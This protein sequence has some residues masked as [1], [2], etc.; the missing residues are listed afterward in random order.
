MFGY[1]KYAFKMYTY[2]H[3]FPK[4]KYEDLLKPG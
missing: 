3:K 2:L 1:S 4:N